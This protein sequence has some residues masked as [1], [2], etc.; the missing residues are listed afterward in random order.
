MRSP[1]WQNLTSLEPW[2][3]GRVYTSAEVEEGAL[4]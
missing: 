3:N 1:D 4:G 2:T